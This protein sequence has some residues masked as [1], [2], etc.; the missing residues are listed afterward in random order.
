MIGCVTWPFRLV[1][2][3]VLVGLIYLG[4]V[5]RDTVRR[6]VHRATSEKPRTGPGPTEA[7]VSMRARLDSL[8]KRRVDSIVLTPQEAEQL[9][10][11]N[12]PARAR[13]VV[14][15]LEVELGDGTVSLR[16]QVEAD[17]VAKELPGP[18]AS[19]LGRRPSLAVRGPAQL[20]RATVGE[21]RLEEVLVRGIPVPKSVWDK[22][23][24]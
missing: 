12:L 16:G 24:S 4:W 19:A 10:L 1:A 18:L 5:N 2:I 8:A 15:S 21:W 6:W 13:N 14:D 7:R 17:S 9:V 22:V 23:L 11:A 3:L 20:L